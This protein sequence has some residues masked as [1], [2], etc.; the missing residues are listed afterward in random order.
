MDRDLEA[1]IEHAPLFRL[2]AGGVWWL[3]RLSGGSR[4]VTE[5][6]GDG[7]CLYQILDGDAVL[8]QQQRRS[9]QVRNVA[10]RGRRVLSIAAKYEPRSRACDDAPRP[11]KLTRPAA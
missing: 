8:A 10:N 2:L 6:T 9:G 7:Q 4:Y 5:E 1:L 3:C 11:P